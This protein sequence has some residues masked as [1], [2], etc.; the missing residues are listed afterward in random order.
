MDKNFRM[1]SC[2]E[3]L[4]SEDQALSMVD[5]MIED[6]EAEAVFVRLVAGTER[7]TRYSENQIT[8]N[9]SKTEL[10]IAITSHFGTRSATATTTDLSEDAITETLRRSETLARIAPEDPEWVPVL[11]PQ[12]YSQRTP[13]FDE[14][15]LNFSPL[16]R[17]ETIKTVCDLSLNAGVNGAGILSTNATVLALGNSKGVRGYN[18]YTQADFSFTAR[19]DDGSSWTERTAWRIEDLPITLLTTEVIAR[20]KNS[21]QPREIQPGTYA[22]VFEGAA[23]ATLLEGVI[24]DLD[25]RFADEGRSF[26]SRTDEQGKPIGNRLGEPLFSPLVEVK[27]DPSHPLLQSTTFFEDGLPNTPLEIITAGIPQN[28]AYS[29]YWALKQNQPPT[30]WLFPVVM[31]GSSQSVADLIAQTERGIF[32]SRA[33]YVRYVNPK[34]LE[35]TGM[36]RD[37][38]FWI[39]E[40]QIAYPI[41]NLR[42]NQSLPEMLHGVEALS[43][44]QRYG[45]NVV[46]GVKVKSFQFSSVTDSV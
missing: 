39:E 21:R 11:E 20:A 6:S 46:P 44:S 15:T 8:Q 19:I 9:L 17:G 25:A 18:R 41:K 30:G 34:T 2:A 7:I 26:M 4:I 43:Q 42:F 22:V 23:F 40:G 16:E 14:A 29:R 28:L 37:G 13:G 27:R 38:T 35:V 33:W 10:Q 32:V 36:T 3:T 24:W 45:N 12:V 1:L 31:T 5:Q